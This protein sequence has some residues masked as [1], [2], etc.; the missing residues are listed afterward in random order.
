MPVI[1]ELATLVT[2][3]T[4]PFTRGMAKAKRSAKGFAS[5]VRGIGA[6][7]SGFLARAPLV[8]GLA[9]A[10][11]VGAVASEFKRLSAEID[12]TAKT[13][14][15]LNVPVEQLQRLRH[16]AAL[17]AGVTS[18]TLDTALQRL[19]KN[20]AKAAVGT[21]EGVRVF[22]ELGLEARQLA[23]LTPDKI[24]L[25]LADA[26]RGVPNEAHAM[27]LV[28]ALMDTEAA[29][30]VNTLREGSAALQQMTVDLKVFSDID[31][32]K[33]EQ[34]GDAATEMTAAI[35]ALKIEA[36][37][38]S[39]PLV[40]FLSH[41]TRFTVQEGRGAGSP[42]DFFSN[43]AAAIRETRKE[44]GGGAGGG[45][46]DLIDIG[47]VQE[48]ARR[49]ADETRRLKAEI[50]G[51]NRR[52]E[53]VRE[54]VRT[55]FETLRDTI[56]DLNELFSRGAINAVT[57]SRAIAQ[58]RGEFDSLRMARDRF[59][60][61]RTVAGTDARTSGGVAASQAAT[62]AFNEFRLQQQRQQQLQAETNDLLRDLVINTG[63]PA[64]EIA[65]VSF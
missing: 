44:L 47:K 31:A 16:A 4:D 17:T 55:P 3:R 54:S 24:F 61:P 28:I 42:L 20:T 2:A 29:G 11:S 7:I 45:G 46:R 22:Q 18:G 37:V 1:G 57:Y 38:A 13:A 14:R 63:E 36:A 40:E 43:I 6:E 52:G 27:R 58:A 32:A 51:L 5:E 15:K 64:I 26:I 8:S 39:G 50:E 30:L 23:Q 62:S 53:Q 60:R 59:T 34:A 9:G 49:A 12:S 33:I 10:L 56:G 25:R 19:A 41:L 35:E 21:G 65:E 48:D